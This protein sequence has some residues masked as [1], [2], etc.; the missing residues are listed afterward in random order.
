VYTLVLV[1][2]SVSFQSVKSTITNPTCLG[3]LESSTGERDLLMFL[4]SEDTLHRRITTPRYPHPHVQTPETPDNTNQPRTFIYRTQLP[5]I[6]IREGGSLIINRS[7]EHI[8]LYCWFKNGCKGSFV[9]LPSRKESVFYFVRLIQCGFVRESSTNSSALL[10]YP[11]RRSV[12][13]C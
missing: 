7:Q 8:T 11:R 10:T 1:I 2:I 5:T 3:L 13:S 6:L 12:S 9:H 4:G